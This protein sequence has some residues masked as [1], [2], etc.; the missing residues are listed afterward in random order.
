[1]NTY[2]E[3]T[4]VCTGDCD[5]LIKYTIRDGYGW[6]NGELDLSC[7]CGSTCVLLSVDDVTIEETTTEKE[8]AP[9]DQKTDTVY[10][11]EQF[12]RDALAK[13]TLRVGELEEH[14]QKVTQRDYKNAGELQGIRDSMHEW[15]TGEFSSLGINQEQAEQIAEIC[16]FELSTEVEVEVTVTY[17]LTLNVPAGE[18]AEDI[19]ED[20][21]FDAIT[22]DTDKIVNVYSSVDRIDI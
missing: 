15:T 22:Y 17:S 13:S 2:Q 6:A 18:T 21:D 16:G 9:M 4:W 12:L 19:V 8:V 11:T 1:M 10:A 5:A 7:R 3:Y 20:I 14:I